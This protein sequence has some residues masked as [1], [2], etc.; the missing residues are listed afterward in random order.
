MARHWVDAAIQWGRS[1]RQTPERNAAAIFA[2]FPFSDDV[3]EP[4]S[5]RTGSTLEQLERPLQE[6]MIAEHPR[7]SPSRASR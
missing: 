6:R 3:S 5:L 2:A 4:S 7:E 1:R